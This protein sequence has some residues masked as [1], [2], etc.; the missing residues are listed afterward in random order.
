MRGNEPP[1]PPHPHRLLKPKCPSL[2][3]ASRNRRDLLTKGEGKENKK[4]GS[5]QR[6]DGSVCGSGADEE[7]PN[8]K[9]G[10]RSREAGAAFCPVPPPERRRSLHLLSD[11]VLVTPSQD[12]S[13]SP[14]NC[15]SFTKTHTTRLCLPPLH[16][17]PAPAA[18]ISSAPPPPPAPAAPS[19]LLITTPSNLPRAANMPLITLL[20]I[21]VIHN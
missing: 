1:H 20:R 21:L 9:D 5:F 11:L 4:N 14:L 8:D 10:A 13:L 2:E 7:G 6:T 17:V 18:T 19:L 12:P 15:P 16:T 3:N